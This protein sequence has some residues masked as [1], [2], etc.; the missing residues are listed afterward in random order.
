MLSANWTTAGDSPAAGAEAGAEAAAE[1]G[2]E[3]VAVGG[4]LV[5]AISAGTTEA[6]GADCPHAPTT[7]NAVASTPR[8]FCGDVMSRIISSA[9]RDAN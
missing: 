4:E 1:A 7:S 3:T 8:R 9:A 5:D 6:A 2:A